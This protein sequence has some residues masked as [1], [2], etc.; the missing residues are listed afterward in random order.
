VDKIVGPGNRWVAERVH[1]GDLLERLR[2][3][4]MTTDARVVVEPSLGTLAELFLSWT[5]AST[6][7]IDPESI[8]LLGPGWPA[9]LESHRGI[10]GDHLF[11]HVRH[12]ATPVEAA[13]LA[14]AAASRRMKAAR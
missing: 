10:V 4:V 9:Y 1:A 7:D 2:H 14:L 6:G 3:L 12:V 5:L 11:R 8:V 13:S